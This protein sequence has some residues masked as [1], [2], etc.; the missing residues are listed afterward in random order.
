MRVPFVSRLLAVMLLCC[1]IVVPARAEVILGFDVSELVPKLVPTVVSINFWHMVPA[2]DENGNPL[3]D[4]S[5]V[6]KPGVGSGYIVDSEGLILTNRHVTDGAQDLSVTLSDGTQMPAA[7][8]YRSPDIDLAVIRVRPKKPLPTIT[9]GDSDTMREGT[10]VIA[11]G[12]PLGLGFTVT[13]GMVSARDRDIK[14]TPLDNFMQ[15]DAPINP[16]NSGGP[17]FNLQGEVIGQNTALFTVGGGESGSVGLNF[18][19]PANDIKFIMAELKKYGRVRAG[20]FGAVAQDLTEEMAEAAGLPRPEGVVV[21][22]VQ[23]GSPADQAKI[24]IGDIIQQATGQ[25]IAGQTRT[26][27]I[28]NVRRLRRVIE[29]SEIGGPLT[30][31]ILRDGA[32]LTVAV[33]TIERESDP[34][35]RLLVDAV[36]PKR[37]LSPTLGLTGEPVTDALRKQFGIPAGINGMVVTDVKPN[38]MGADLNIKPGNVVVRINGTDTVSREAMQAA[39]QKA[40]NEGHQFLM[41]LV[42]D[43][44]GMHWIGVPVPPPA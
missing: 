10:S 19:I 43:T 29:A 1:A 3:P 12:N 44:S 38:T 22:W 30:F 34:S 33:K 26:V 6:R 37:E 11:I 36:P 31:Q 32:K 5:Q 39:I 20:Y 35:N 9:W 18:A 24:K 14:E 13:H 4:G 16:G 23:P 42:L 7:L 25:D 40:R 28:N 8:A 2:V 41:V 17:L 21:V 15:I 27:N